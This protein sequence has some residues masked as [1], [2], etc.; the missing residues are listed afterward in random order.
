MTRTA[1]WGDRIALHC[2]ITAADGT[3]AVSTFGGE[4][5]ILTLG[6]GE[7]EPR[8]ESCLI[9]LEIGR[10]Y[11]FHLEPEEAFG[12]PE[13][14]RIQQVPLTAFPAGAPPAVGSLVEFDLG[15]GRSATG[16]IKAAGTDIVTVDFNHPLSGC[17]V[18]FEVNIVEIMEP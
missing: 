1:L 10:R 9:D 8:L 3:E 16:H 18:T 12:A 5:L 6:E 14:E 13:P 15:E 17:A 7:I 4:P 11:V 2:R